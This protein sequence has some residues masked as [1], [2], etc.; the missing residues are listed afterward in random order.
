MS[1]PFVPDDLPSAVDI[2]AAV[3][4]G[5]RSARDVLEEHLARIDAHEVDIHAFNLVLADE[6]RATADAIDARVMQRTAGP[7]E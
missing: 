4:S 3:R 1:G 6:A 5:T 7:A 2:A